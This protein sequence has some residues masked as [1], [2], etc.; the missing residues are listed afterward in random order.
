MA[1][2]SLFGTPEEAELEFMIQFS[3]PA[4]YSR[5]ALDK[6]LLY[7][8]KRL[9]NLSKGDII[10]A[11]KKLIPV[12]ETS[13]I[14][15]STDKYLYRYAISVIEPS[16]LWEPNIDNLLKLQKEL[17]DVEKGV[18]ILLPLREIVSYLLSDWRE[19]EGIWRR[20]MHWEPEKWAIIDAAYASAKYTDESFEDFINNLRAEV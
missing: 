7:L 17:I 2:K 8:D 19:E 4:K 10:T 3:N 14:V 20:P 18:D 9:P 13:D 16:L 6:Q 11:L 12:W 5:A 15:K 1:K